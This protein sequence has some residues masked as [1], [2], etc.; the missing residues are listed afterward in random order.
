[1]SDTERSLELQYETGGIQNG[2]E[3]P[4]WIWSAMFGCYAIFFLFI[5]LATGRD[6]QALFA[7]IISALYTTM[8]FSTAAVLASLKGRER[9]SPLSRGKFLQTYT[10]PMN[11][12]AVAGQVL[13]IPVALAIFAIAVTIIIWSL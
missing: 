2:F 9:P 6:G 11:L 13:A 1:M 4:G 3:F 10:G 5:T 8:Y 12:P 7:I